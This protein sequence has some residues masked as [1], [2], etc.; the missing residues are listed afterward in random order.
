SQSMPSS[1]PA[2]M[3]GDLLKRR[4]DLQQAEAALKAENAR[5]GAAKAALFPQFS[6][7]GAAGFESL[8]L[9]RFISDRA[10]LYQVG[11][12]VTAPLFNAGA[13]R[14]NVRSAQ[15]RTAAAALGYEQAFQTALR[16]AA[17]ALITVTK[18]RAQR[19]EQEQLLSALRETNRLSGLL[20]N[21]GIT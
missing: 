21:G 7:T 5:I 15:A 9:E 8:T 10:K 19:E 11:P 3:P 20:Y 13:L 12:I 14:A 16:E 17:D 1:I 4:P 6:L 2:G 18:T